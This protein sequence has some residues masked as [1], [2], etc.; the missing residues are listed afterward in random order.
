[1]PSGS[2]SPVVCAGMDSQLCHY[3]SAVL[4]NVQGGAQ[5]CGATLRLIADGKAEVSSVPSSDVAVALVQH[6]FLVLCRAHPVLVSCRLRN[7]SVLDVLQLQVLPNG[8]LKLETGYGS[9]NILGAALVTFPGHLPLVA[10]NSCT[11]SAGKM[12]EITDFFQHADCPL[13]RTFQA[14][15]RGSQAAPVQPPG[16]SRCVGHLAHEASLAMAA[17]TSFAVQVSEA[18]TG[19][20]LPAPSMLPAAHRQRNRPPLPN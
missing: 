6:S 7:C 4:C 1:M 13:L 3:S 5:L 12:A 9:C 20:P 17:A 8:R 10:Y 2:A 19:V 14:S 15:F 16:P 18:Q 11:L